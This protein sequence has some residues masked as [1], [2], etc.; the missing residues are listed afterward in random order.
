[1][2]VIVLRMRED[3]VAQ[4]TAIAVELAIGKCLVAANALA[5]HAILRTALAEPVLHGLYLH[6]VPVGPEGAEDA[7]V[8]RHVAVPVSG[9]FPD[10]H[11]R[12]M[13]RL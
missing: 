5:R 9:T 2:I 11:R 8:M 6:V 1:M 3:L 13:R 10:A 7:A 4:V 12:Q